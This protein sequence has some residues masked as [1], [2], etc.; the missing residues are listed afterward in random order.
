[1]TG[2]VR[3][4][5][6]HLTVAAISLY[7]TPAGGAT[8]RSIRVVNVDQP[9]SHTFSLYVSASAGETVAGTEVWLTQPLTVDYTK[10]IEI[11]LNSGDVLVAVADEDN[12]LT[13]EL[14]LW[15]N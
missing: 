10:A 1:M 4:G 7:T 6:E 13:M 12:K 8:L 11:A 9:N 5:P 14:T 2:F 15:Q 3:A